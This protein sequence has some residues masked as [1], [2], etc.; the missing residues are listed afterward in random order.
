MPLGNRERGARGRRG[1]GG[2][3]VAD[4]ER[5]LDLVG[6]AAKG[7]ALRARH[8]C[9]GGLLRDHGHERERLERGQRATTVGVAERGRVPRLPLERDE[10]ACLPGAHAEP[11]GQIAAGRRE[12]HEPI[13]ATIE[14]RPEETAGLPVDLVHRTNDGGHALVEGTRVEIVDAFRQRRHVVGKGFPDGLPV[15]IY[16]HVATLV[17]VGRDHG[18]RALGGPRFAARGARPQP[19]GCDRFGSFTQRDAVAGHAAG[20]L[21]DV[22]PETDEP[23][24]TPE[25]ESHPRLVSAILVLARGPAARVDERRQRAHGSPARQMQPLLLRVRRRHADEEPCLRPRELAGCERGTDVGQALE[26][27]AHHGETLE[28]ACG[29]AEPLAAIVA[30]PCEAE[31]VM[32]PAGQELPR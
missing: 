1:D 6:E 26:T 29:E 20:Q 31:L 3:T 10:S 9:V 8:P 13:E 19:F 28:L 12:Q 32:A 23:R 4:R 16:E 2:K 11:L 24:R 18:R 7:D 27:R 17:G 14:K 25:P 15:E 22:V 30:E 21:D 5:P